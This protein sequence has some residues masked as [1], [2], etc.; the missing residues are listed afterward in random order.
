MS[1]P[2]IQIEELDSLP[3]ILSL[4][5]KMDILRLIDTIFIPHKNWSG[6]SVG[7]TVA[8]WLSYIIAHHDHR[9][10]SLEDWVEKRQQILSDFFC[11]PISPKHFTDDRLA[12]ILDYFSNSERWNEFECQLNATI[13]RVYGVFSDLVRI[14]MTTANSDGIVT[15][16]GLLQFGH[17]KDDPTTPQIKIALSV[18]DPLGL[19]LTVSIL[20]GNTADDP[21][22]IPVM[23]SVIKNTNNQRLLFVGDCKMCAL[24]T[25]LHAF[26]HQM[27]YLCPLSEVAHP[28]SEIIEAVHSFESSN[29]IMTPIK[30][31]YYT[32]D[33]AIIAEAFE[34]KVMRSAHKDGMHHSWE[35]RIIYAKSFAHAEKQKAKLDSNLEKSL[36]EIFSM[37]ERGRGKPVYRSRSEAEDKIQ[38]VLKSNSILGVIS[39]EIREELTKKTIRAYGNRPKRT[40][41]KISVKVSANVNQEAYDAAIEILGWRA[42]ITNRSEDLLS[43]EAVVLAYRDQ[44]VVEH[45]FHRLKGK[46]LSLTPIHIQK[47][48]RIDG[49]VKLLTIP[50]RILVVID[51]T[52]QDSIAQRGENLSGLFRY[53]PKKELVKPKAER[54]IEYF[55]GVFVSK[56]AMGNQYFTS[57]IGLEEKH[58]EILG[59]LN[60]SVDIFTAFGVIQDT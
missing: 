20:P 27:D 42:Y 59:L 53:N 34:K 48:E 17:S 15:E 43:I 26:L 8:I 24:G 9:M 6:L 45:A 54:I 31:E 16:S 46:C 39:Y 32:G 7:E 38:S 33:E 1:Q 50:L 57:I 2:Q 25:R 22:Y 10:C 44:Y 35:E 3:I 14:D 23:D 5:K 55:K 28:T 37:N 51:K 49:L 47:D 56:V 41:K 4:L 12:R 58:M 60:L 52:L 19:P 21:L 30:R 40:D 36:D 18:L 29:G 11:H 13:I